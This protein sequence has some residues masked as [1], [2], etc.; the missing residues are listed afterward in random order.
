M[1]ADG[2]GSLR[3]PE[4][5]LYQFGNKLLVNNG[6]GAVRAEVQSVLIVFIR[7]YAVVD[8]RSGT[9]VSGCAAF[10]CGQLFLLV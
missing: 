5:F 4:T 6:N 1:N 7:G 8:L 10:I 2:N 3:L 9:C